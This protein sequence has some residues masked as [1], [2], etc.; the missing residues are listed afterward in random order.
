MCVVESERDC[1]FMDRYLK[2]CN[3]IWA[4]VADGREKAYL[5]L[6]IITPRDASYIFKDRYRSVLGSIAGQIHIYEAFPSVFPHHSSSLSI[7]HI[8]STTP[9][10]ARPT[11]LYLNLNILH[12][13]S[14][15]FWQAP[16][17]PSFIIRLHNS[18]IRRHIRRSHDKCPSSWS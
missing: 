11:S 7:I 3:W 14:W 5:T 15:S 6:T 12:L 17:N 2:R 16:P 18:S 9:P 4:S 1:G 13:T 10:F 8:I